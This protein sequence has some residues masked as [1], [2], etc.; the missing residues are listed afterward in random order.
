MATITTKQK[1]VKGNTFTQFTVRG[2]GLKPLITNNKETAQTIKD[3][4]TRLENAG[5]EKT[6]KLQKKLKLVVPLKKFK[7]AFKSKKSRKVNLGNKLAILN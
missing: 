5:F 7:G 4:R 1:G 6:V 3:A 2:A